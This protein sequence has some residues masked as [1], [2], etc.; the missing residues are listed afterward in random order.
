MKE[1]ELINLVRK[2]GRY[3][4]EAPSKL[5]PNKISEDWT[6]LNLI[7]PLM[8]GL[9]WENP[10][11]II[12]GDSSINGDWIDYTLRPSPPESSSICIEAK[13]LLLPP[14]RDRN[15]EQIKKG[16]EQTKA[17]GSDYFAWTNGDTWQLFAVKLSD[18]PM[19]EIRIGQVD[20]D[21][22]K[23]KPTID[24][25]RL[26][27]RET[28]V[29][30]PQSIADQIMANWKERA[31]PQALKALSGELAEETSRLM[32]S[33][34]PP[35]LDISS[36]EILTFLKECRWEEIHTMQPT[37]E[38]SE[39]WFKPCP[40]EWE[41]LVASRD[42]KYIRARET[43]SKDITRKLGEYL[44]G[45]KYEPFLDTVTY[46]LL[47]FNARGKETKGPTGNAI[48]LYRRYGFIETENPQAGRG[49]ITYKRV[50]DAMPYLKR[51]L[52]SR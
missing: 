2:L 37:S 36:E 34:L 45:D 22:S 13:H 12:P 29:N 38:K 48:M 11:E 16:L 30:S 10:F 3:I 1:S 19:Y 23:I 9:G 5:P 15:H 24:W 32:K 49:K 18:A 51:I 28:V 40:A 25:L 39:S 17:R 35:Q 31:L 50:D 4:T 6:R 7:D 41:K 21:E 14:P 44:I 46:S 27:S 33:V 47:G 43:L 52:Q 42:P 26:L 8:R 20:R